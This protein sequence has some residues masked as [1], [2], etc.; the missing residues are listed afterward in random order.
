MTTSKAAR[1]RPLRAAL[2]ALAL[3]L[4]A[5]AIPV[6]AQHTVTLENGD[7]LTGTL[8]SVEGEVWKVRFA[9]NEAELPVSQV[10]SLQTDGPIGVRLSDGTILA[11][12]IIPA[13]SGLQIVGADG[14]AQTISPAALLAVGDPGDL[15]A[16]APVQIGLFRPIGRFWNANMAVGFSDKSGNSRARGLSG[17]F[18]LAR[19]SPKDRL[20]LTAG[21]NREA[22]EVADA[23]FETTVSK[24]YV[25]LRVDI[26]FTG[27]FFVF[28]S[29][30]QERDRF[31]DISLRS[32][33]NAGFGFQAVSTDNTDLR[34]SLSGG[35]RRES[36]ISEGSAT[37]GV[38]AIGSTVRQTV[39]PAVFAWQFDLTPN[40]EEFSD[41]RLVSDASVTAPLYKGI[42]VRFGILNEVNNRPQPGIKKHDMLVTTRLS[43]TIG[44]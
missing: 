41:F 42:G 5:A 14:T 17:T 36:F 39:G 15:A 19:R 2:F 38:A 4:A 28:T 16:L 44:Q 43:Y 37:A 26:S 30:R 25:Q 40:V 3:S 22:S 9:G 21:F 7:R 32:T 24:Y 13:P 27:R 12:T 1:M 33:Y 10:V 20:T 8:V 29:T 31:Q 34:F 23:G 11:T 6:H 18:E 35:A